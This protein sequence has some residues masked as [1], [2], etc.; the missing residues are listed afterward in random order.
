MEWLI[1]LLCLCTLF[2]PP[3]LGLGI[4][5]VA[6]RRIGRWAFVLGWLF[7]F[8]FITLFYVIYDAALRVF[9]CEPNDRLACGNPIADAFLLFV[10]IVCSIAIANALAQVA[11]YLFLNARRTRQLAN[12]YGEIEN[13]LPQMELPPEEP[14]ESA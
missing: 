12:E 7:P 13:E 3:L 14:L 4:A 1:S 9:P 5:F 11:L 8:I 6:Q 10:G 2:V